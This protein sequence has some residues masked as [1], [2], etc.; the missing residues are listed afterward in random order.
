VIRIQLTGRALQD[1]SYGIA[2]YDDQ[3]PGIGDYFARCLE[4]EI[5]GLR[6]TAGIHRQCYA[7]YHR[8]IS[9]TFPYA[10]FYTFSNE[11]AVIWAVVDCRRNPEWIRAHLEE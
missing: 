5:E 4:S 10:I 6:V 2:F 3:E 1:L 9:R 8:L 11:T 7:D